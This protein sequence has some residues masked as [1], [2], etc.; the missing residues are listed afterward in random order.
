MAKGQRLSSDGA[1]VNTAGVGFVVQETQAMFAVSIP[2]LLAL[3]F[4]VAVGLLVIGYREKQ[5]SDRAN[6]LFRV[7]FILLGVMTALTPISWYW[8]RTMPSGTLLMGISDMF[9]LGL[10]TLVGGIIIGVGL[11]FRLRTSSMSTDT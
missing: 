3:G 10:G 8:S 7:G 1:V 4:G 2:S 9:V 11:V 6:T 5:N